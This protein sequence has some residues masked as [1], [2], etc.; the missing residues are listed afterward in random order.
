MEFICQGV[1]GS[2]S[3]DAGELGEKLQDVG[4]KNKKSY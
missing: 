3:S 4:W 1:Y 2:N